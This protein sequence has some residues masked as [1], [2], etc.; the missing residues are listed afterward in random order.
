MSTHWIREN[1]QKSRATKSQK[2]SSRAKRCFGFKEEI[3]LTRKPKNL[4][5]V[6]GD[7]TSYRGDEHQPFWTWLRH[8]FVDPKQQVTRKG[9]DGQEY[10]RDFMASF[11]CTRAGTPDWSGECVACKRNNPR[12][13]PD[14]RDKRISTSSV[15]HWTVI[16]LAWYYRFP[17]KW[18]DIEWKQP[19]SAREEAQFREAGYEK[20]FGK[21][22]YL[23][24]GPLHA[25]QFD[26]NVFKTLERLCSGCE[27]ELGPEAKYDGGLEPA[28]FRCKACGDVVEDLAISDWTGDQIDSVAFGEQDVQCPSCGHVDIPLIDWGCTQCTTPKEVNLFDCVIPL[29]KF[30]STT[31]SGKVQ[32]SIQIPSGKRILFGTDYLLPNGEQLLGKDLDGNLHVNPVMEDL[33]KPIDFKN[34]LFRTQFDPEYQKQ[35]T[36]GALSD[37]AFV[38]RKK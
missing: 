15:Q 7:Y 17:N 31:E 9:S 29:S 4:L 19:S 22:G 3:Y 37:Q 38:P 18:G 28:M 33:Y 35:L 1:R 6:P 30:V 16:D 14:D 26:D 27:E 20:V 13:D 11:M 23:N 10:Q 2:S 12:M 32:S 36:N 8:K 24:F 21:R 34:D 5:F 25:A